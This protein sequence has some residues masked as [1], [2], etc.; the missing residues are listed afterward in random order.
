MSF[1]WQTYCVNKTL[2]THL[3]PQNYCSTKY[4]RVHA[5]FSKFHFL[6]FTDYLSWKVYNLSWP[7]QEIIYY[8]SWPVS[9]KREFWNLILNEWLNFIIKSTIPSPWL[10]TLLNFDHLKLS[11]MTQFITHIAFLH[12]GLRKFWNL[13]FQKPPYWFNFTTWHISIPSLWLQKILKFAHLK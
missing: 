6:T 11:R 7:T 13:T 12:H 1:M 3:F 4:F 8:F 10:R 9:W 5:L 2:F